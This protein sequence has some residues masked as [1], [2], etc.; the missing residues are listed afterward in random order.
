MLKFVTVR[1]TR[2]SLLQVPTT[3]GAL[4]VHKVVIER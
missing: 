2:P 1:Y 4:E 3:E